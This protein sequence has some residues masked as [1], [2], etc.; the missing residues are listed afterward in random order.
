MV[1][2]RKR[3]LWPHG[4]LSF[5]RLFFHGLG[6]GKFPI[7]VWLGAWGT[8]VQFTSLPDR[9]PTSVTGHG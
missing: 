3:A 5:A 4:L 6:C 1:C 9:C 8:R 2:L 7:P